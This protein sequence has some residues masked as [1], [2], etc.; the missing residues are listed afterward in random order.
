MALLIRYASII[1]AYIVVE[2]KLANK[3]TP[4]SST[5]VERISTFLMPNNF[6]NY[7]HIING[8]SMAH[9]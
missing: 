4:I 6:K 7:L 1:H 2:G 3:H 9:D 8:C 5:Q